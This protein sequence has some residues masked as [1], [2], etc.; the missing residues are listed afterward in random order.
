MSKL[1]VLHFFLTASPTEVHVLDAGHF[2]LDTNADEI[3]ALVDQFMK[4]QK[5]ALAF[6]KHWPVRDGQGGKILWV[7]ESHYWQFA[8][9]C[10]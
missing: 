2:A 5:W 3:A 1:V 10:P 9:S 7:K 8:C 4:A 6:A